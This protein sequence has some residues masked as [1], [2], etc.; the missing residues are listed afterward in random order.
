MAFDFDLNKLMQDPNF[1]S[2]IGLLGA[3][4][5][6]N[7]P[8]LTAFKMLQ[9]QEQSKRER[10]QAQQMMEYRRAQVEASRAGAARLGEQTE[11]SRQ[12]RLRREANQ[13]W[14]REVLPQLM[15]GGQV[16]GMQMPGQAP[17]QQLPQPA[18]PQPVPLPPIGGGVT[19]P[20][21]A[22]EAAM[23]SQVNQPMGP[24]PQALTREIQATTQ[25]LLRVGDPSSRMQLT[26]HLNDLRQQQANLNK[27]VVSG[28]PE[29]QIQ[30]LHKP[31]TPTGPTY[32]PDIKIDEKG[33]IELG[34]KHSFEPQKIQQKQQEIG[35]AADELKVKQDAE[36]RH[37][38]EL[39]LKRNADARERRTAER[40]AEE[41]ALEKRNVKARDTVAYQTVVQSVERTQ[42]VV[43]SLLNDK[44]LPVV[45]GRGGLLPKNAAAAI[46]P[47]WANTINDIEQ[48]TSTRINEML[49]SIRQAVPT[50]ASGYGQFQQFEKEMFQAIQGLDRT[51]DPKD[52]R[53]KLAEMDKLIS[54]YKQSAG[55][56][57]T[58]THGEPAPPA[59]EGLP[60]G[61][62]YM[63]I[64]KETNQPY[65]RTPDGKFVRSKRRK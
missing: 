49:Q 18:M 1:V 28:S 61:T 31:A 21:N 7:A 59:Y 20:T 43:E 29:K 26:E 14:L 47:E 55:N 10:E 27:R 37:A 11:E 15:Q 42:A 48:V 24:D 23:R 60:A 36:R 4:S 53:N 38:E 44:N 65:Y 17:Q 35:I 45:T 58:Q 54:E 41:K 19:G 51:R 2:G 22:G 39:E 12:E 63:G 6:R 50:G 57:F 5:P 30:Q 13:K 56:I 8:L 9:Q 46:N 25:D 33:D 52:F 16:P 40:I 32:L 3:A 64:D 62:R 34:L